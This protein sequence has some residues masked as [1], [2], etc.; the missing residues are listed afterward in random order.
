MKV[1]GATSVQTY[2]AKLPPDR[3]DVIATMR[4]VVNANVPAGYEEGFGF[5]MIMWAVPL[6]RFPNTYNGQPL[7]YVALAS[8]KNHFALY[9]TC[10]YGDKTREQE[11]REGFARDGKRLDMGKSCVRFQRID[12]L[13]LATIEKTIAGVPPE[14]L[15]AMHDSVHNPEARAKR[16]AVRAKTAAA[17]KKPTARKPVA[18]AKP[19]A[20]KKPVSRKKSG[21]RSARR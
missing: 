6:S 20:R 14:T 10:V 12:Q 5:G 9:L 15:M 17:K 8:Q 7:C 18:K 13:S 11:F 21:A 4:D 1:A 19:V 3:R 2:L 16:S